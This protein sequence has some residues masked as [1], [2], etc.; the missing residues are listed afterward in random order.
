MPT[1]TDA[2]PY[3]LCRTHL[4]AGRTRKGRSHY[5]WRAALSGRYESF[6]CG[7][8]DAT[9]AALPVVPGQ[10]ALTARPAPAFTDSEPDFE[11]ESVPDP[12]S[13]SEP[14][15]GFGATAA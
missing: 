13:E 4:R 7:A 6:A 15:S 8:R 10:E 2:H 9:G 11:S 1:S 14:D 3:L 12:A 5:G